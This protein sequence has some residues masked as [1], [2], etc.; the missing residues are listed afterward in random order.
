MVSGAGQVDKEEPVL[1]R[2]IMQDGEVL[3]DSG[4]MRV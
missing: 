4:K 3:I 1:W 2:M